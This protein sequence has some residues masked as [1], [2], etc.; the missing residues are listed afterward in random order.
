MSKRLIKE[1]L[2]DISSPGSEIVRIHKS[3]NERRK[4]YE[5]TR[6]LS[7]IEFSSS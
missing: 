5:M 6:K 3:M 1:W 2:A 4:E 7:S